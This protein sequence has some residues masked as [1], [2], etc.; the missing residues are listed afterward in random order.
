MPKI[1]NW[2]KTGSGTW[3]YDP[4]PSVVLQAF[5]DRSRSGR[6]PNWVV[7]LYRDGEELKTVSHGGDNERDALDRAREFMRENTLLDFD[8][9]VGEETDV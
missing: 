5:N 4:D 6:Y 8:V 3:E 9:L 2:T 7:K 1:E